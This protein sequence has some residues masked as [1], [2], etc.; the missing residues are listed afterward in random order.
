MYDF[1]SEKT[2]EGVAADVSQ[3]FGV[4]SKEWTMFGNSMGKIYNLGEGVELT[5]GR[6]AGRYELSFATSKFNAEDQKAG[7]EKQNRNAPQLKF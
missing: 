2:F 1:N 4:K 7:D 3:Q 6:G 5:L